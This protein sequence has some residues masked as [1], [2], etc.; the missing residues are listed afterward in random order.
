MDYILIEKKVDNNETVK[1]IT[2]DYFSKAGRTIE[3]SYLVSGK[4][5]YVDFQFE[6]KRESNRYYLKLST[7]LRVNVAIGELQILDDIL[8]RSDINKYISV[9]RAYDGISEALCKKLYPKYAIFERKMRQLILL[10]LTKAFGNKWID[11]TISENTKK[12]LKEKTKG[13]SLKT[14]EVLE[15]LDLS[16]LENY[17]FEENEINYS[18]Y[19]AAELSKEN[20]GT[21][22][23][24]EL[25]EKIDAMRP[26]SLW[27]KVFSDIGSADEWQN[28]ISEIHECRNRIAHHKAVT[29]A[30]F[31]DIN[32]KINRL[33]KDIDNAIMQIQ[34]RDFTDANTLE[35]LSG[36]ATMMSQ[37]SQNI[38]EQYDF[39]YWAESFNTAIGRMLKSIRNDMTQNMINSLK[40]ASINLSASLESFRLK[41][42]V[43]ESLKNFSELSKGARFYIEKSGEKQPEEKASNDNSE[44]IELEK[45][46][47]ERFDETYNDSVNSDEKEK[48]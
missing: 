27:D 7:K 2:L 44:K 25:V 35:V 30:L 13:G 12:D 28:K 31:N 6:H 10:V 16:Q 1:Q 18:E 9:I 21:M 23:E 17:L 14:N 5:N 46:R 8:I 24:Q 34:N 40:V 38:F 43:V 22:N 3:E 11:K 32:K 19:L 45:E 26:Q 42:E 48:T 33:N 39:S 47:D 4:G 37:V 41:S 15:L 20:I 29:Q 36:F